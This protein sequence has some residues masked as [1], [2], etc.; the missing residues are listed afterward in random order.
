MTSAAQIRPIC[1]QDADAWLAMRRALWP[2]PPDDHAGEIATFF[3]GRAT[4]PLAVFVAERDGSC[5][6]I[7]ELAI[8]T[9]LP[10]CA[11]HRVGY[12]EGLYIVPE[13]RGSSL[14]KELLRVAQGWAR[15]HECVAFAS[16]RADQLIFDPRYRL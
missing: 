5:V 8:R 16:D 6:A 13:H 3:E 9:D 12:V 1:A 15:E 7:M 2:E 10:G 14:A 11:A 4:D